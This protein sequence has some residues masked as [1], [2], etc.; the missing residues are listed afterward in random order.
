MAARWARKSS[1][2]STGTNR[3]PSAWALQSARFSSSASSAASS[4]AARA[5]AKCT[6]LQLRRPPRVKAALSIDLGVVITAP[7]G[8]RVA[9]WEPVV[10]LTPT[11]SVVLRRLADSIPPIRRI[12]RRHHRHGG[13]DNGD[14]CRFDILLAFY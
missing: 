9:I 7:W 8:P 13:A 2:G 14:R 10:L 11:D 6:R 1:R 5:A 4:D 12:Q 3:S